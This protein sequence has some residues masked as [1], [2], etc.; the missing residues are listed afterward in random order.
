MG[1]NRLQSR[2]GWCIRI[3]DK[4]LGPR[5]AVTGWPGDVGLGP[6]SDFRGIGVWGAFGGGYHDYS[7][8]G[9]GVSIGGIRN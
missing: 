4:T 7:G 1:W 8:D 2:R 5:E 9:V 6:R 3:L